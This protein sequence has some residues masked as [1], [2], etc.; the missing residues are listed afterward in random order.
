MGKGTDKLYITHSE[1]AS[2]EGY[3]ASVG[4]RGGDRAG[5][6]STTNAGPRPAFKRLPFNFCALTLQPFRHPVCTPSGIIFDLT[7]ILPWLKKHGDTNPVDGSP[8]P[9]T[10][11]IRLHFG[12]NED[13]SGEYVDPVTFKAFTD[14]THI[15]AVRTTGNVYAWDTVQ[16]LNVRPKM[17]RDLLTDEPFVRADLVTLQDPLNVQARDLSAFRFLKDGGPVLVR[18]EGEG[19][20][21]GE[22]EGGEAAVDRSAAKVLKAKEAVDRARKER[23]ARAQQAAARPN[24]SLSLSSSGT[25]TATGGS[26]TRSASSTSSGRAAIPYNAAQHTTGK[27]AASFTST[28]LTPHTSGERALLSEE[29]YMLKGRRVKNKGYARMRTTVGELKL[30]LQTEYAPR[31]VWNFVR[32]AQRGYYRDVPFHRNIRNF[33]IQGGDPTGTGKGGASIWGKNFADEFDGPLTHDARGLLSMAN[34][35]KNTNSS[36]FFITYRPAKHLDRKHTIFGRVVDGLDTLARMENTTTDAAD[37]PTEPLVIEDVVVFVDPFAD[38]AQAQRDLRDAEGRREALR[39]AG[40]ADEDRT[41]WT[42]KRV[43]ALG[44]GAGGGGGG[45]VGVGTNGAHRNPGKEE[46]DDEAEEEEGMGVGKYLKT[47]T[48]AAAPAA[49]ARSHTSGPASHADLDAASASAFDG[50]IGIGVGVPDPANDEDDDDDEAARAFKRARA[51]HH[52]PASVSAGAGTGAGF[53][54]FD[55]W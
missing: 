14:H 10:D 45:G 38:F 53:G 44:V 25:A 42:G 32:L 47:K 31:A 5:S 2:A 51:Q 29:E 55:N 39:R 11:L 33:M 40:G 41:T 23:A 52:H 3:S 1:W 43:R 18:G 20:G 36:Q 26:T 34:K 28:G 21:E 9:A 48:K 4:A 13:G 22:E 54:N 27:A 15:V 50:G 49:K 30:E 19:E 37:R 46:E 12:T 24:A 8:L 6:R 16:R 35:G 17:W 7:A